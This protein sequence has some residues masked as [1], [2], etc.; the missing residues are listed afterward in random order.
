MSKRSI[1]RIV[2]G[3]MLVLLL[4]GATACTSWRAQQLVPS[5]DAGQLPDRAYLVT[6]R[7]GSQLL[8]RD[9][10]LHADTLH[11]R[12]AGAPRGMQGESI[13]VPMSEVA[14]V[15]TR[16]FSTTRTAGLVGGALVLITAGSAMVALAAV[17]TD[18]D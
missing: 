10:R 12:L 6:R 14:N 8:V 16:R 5:P 3:L 17:T 18:W 11:A 1:R 2:H 15:E 9:A 13:A 7:D 4:P